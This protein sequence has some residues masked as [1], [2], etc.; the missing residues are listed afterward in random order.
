MNYSIEDIMERAKELTTKPE[1]VVR[2]EQMLLDPNISFKDIAKVV[3]MDPGLT[4]RA[5]KVANSC[6]F[7]R[8]SKAKTLTE[9][10]VTIGIKGLYSLVLVHLI[11]EYY[12]TF[13]LQ[14]M[15]FWNHS[16]S[17]S[18]SSMI[19][20]TEKGLGEVEDAMVSGLLHDI[21]KDILNSAEPET[22]ADITRKVRCNGIS[23]A[24]S[25]QELF[26]FTHAEVGF[27]L[28]KRWNFPEH[29]QKVILYHH[30]LFCLRQIEKESPASFWLT[31]L[32]NLADTLCI[33]LGMSIKTPQNGF[34]WGDV[35]AAKTLGFSEEQLTE[36]EPVIKTRI[37][38]EKRMF[39]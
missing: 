25:E 10:I 30:N 14:E 34:G 8:L 23:Y 21:G 16:V 26:G 33:R 32:V 39:D 18:I 19:L 11:K 31:S 7:G 37:E 5:F 29:I 17:V 13:G 36:L 6:F 20:A 27:E 22:Y 35:E 24:L 12:K 4:A 3:S 1:I 15:S 2:A 28:A 38:E 9:A